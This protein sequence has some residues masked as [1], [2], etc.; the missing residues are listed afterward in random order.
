MKFIFVKA[1]FN[2]FGRSQPYTD[3]LCYSFFKWRLF[4]CKE[5]KNV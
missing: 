4:I 2:L 5:N 1:H 3:I